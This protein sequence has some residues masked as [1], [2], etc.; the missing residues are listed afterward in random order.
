M[1]D[2]I[3]FPAPGVEPVSP[4]PSVVEAQALT[5]GLQ[6]NSFFLAGGW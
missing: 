2:F 1:Q 3:L 4:M 6:R 5:T